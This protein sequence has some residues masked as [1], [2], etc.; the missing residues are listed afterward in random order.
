M[1][2]KTYP[3]YKLVPNLHPYQRYIHDFILEHPY[4]GLFLDCGLGKTLITLSALY[5]L[6][7]HNHVL[8]VAP[9][10]I[11]R[12]TWI[13]EIDKWDFPF[14]TKSFII[15]EKGKSVTK[16][17]SHELIEEIFTETLPSTI[18]F[19]NRERLCDLIDN[20][21]VY[22]KE[23]GEP[24]QYWFNGQK[25][26]IPI[27]PFK[28]VVLD[29]S[30]SFKSRTSKRFKALQLVR[31]QIERVIELTG[32]PAPNGVEDLWSQ[33]YL[34]DEGQR[35]GKNITTYR[36]N[37]CTKEYSPTGVYE[38]KPHAKDVIYKLISDITVSVDN[39][40]IEVPDITFN[41]MF[42]YMSPKEEKTYKNFK[43]HAVLELAEENVNEA[44]L[45]IDD[46]DANAIIAEN[47][48]VLSGKLR[49]MASG[50][51]YVNDEHDYVT[52]HNR[53]LDLLEHI[54][55]ETP[56]PV[57]IAY[58]FRA[59]EE[60]II[61]EMKNRGH[62]V[63]KFD[64]SPEMI[65]RW[66]NNE[67]KNLLL[68]PASA[69]HGLNL[70]SGDGHTLV[71]YTLPWSLELYKQTNARLHRQGQKN[72]VV[73]HHLVTANTIDEKVLNA[74]NKKDMGQQALLDAVKGEI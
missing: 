49:Q 34:L 72:N 73:I 25:I 22:T 63:T 52:I 1:P 5:D 13:D 39:P 47:A 15:D 59:E 17:K 69:G 68:Q 12:S 36:R 44:G 66:N 57:M 19:I 74:L 35:M 60:K 45:T 20:L 16:K 11:A 32:T 41:D 48:A 24:E 56:T 40:N 64:G 33:I 61:E 10:H 26:N 43:K 8:V 55:S 70:Q 51:I 2:D 28:T 71:W 46:I 9:K 58:Y 3:S 30:Q 21:P 14:N 27:F 31:P 42:A 6:N 38:L 53:K 4:C 65:K 29:E 54:L 62:E 50:T 37:F 7:P 18:Y 23:N 67:I